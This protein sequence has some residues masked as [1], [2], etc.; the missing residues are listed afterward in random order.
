[1]YSSENT[2]T[3]ERGL[4]LLSERE[5]EPLK[6]FTAA[7]SS[8]EESVFTV[9]ELVTVLPAGSMF[10]VPLRLHIQISCHRRERG[11]AQ[12]V[13]TW[14]GGLLA[15]V[16]DVIRASLPDK[17]PLEADEVPKS[18]PR[19]SQFGEVE[20]DFQKMEL[21]R[22]GRLVGLT[23]HEFRT[24]R[25]FLLHPEA[26]ISRDE[27][28]R[29]VWGFHNYPTT[30]TVDNRILRLRQKLEPDPSQ[31]THFLTVHGAGYK[32]VP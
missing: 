12:S 1:M 25:Y 18:S 3:L 19:I 20:V 16:N 9:G 15:R 22:L 11:F 30:R 28:L 4:N 21:R 26:V 5:P 29:Q 7:S 2:Q 31:P 14:V 13:Q 10:P 27:L 32:F 6:R 24:L 23:A 17:D 8:T